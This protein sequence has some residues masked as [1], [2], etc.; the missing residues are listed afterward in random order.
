MI[1]RDESGSCFV[2]KTHLL[3]LIDGIEGGAHFGNVGNVGRPTADAE[4]NAMSFTPTCT[5]T[6]QDIHENDTLEVRSFRSATLG[7]LAP[8]EYQA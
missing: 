2:L 7:K 8:F 1:L 4:H 3:Q 6:D 5:V